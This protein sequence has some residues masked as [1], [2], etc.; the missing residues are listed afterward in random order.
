MGGAYIVVYVCDPSRPVAWAWF[1]GSD[2]YMEVNVFATPS[3]FDF[4]PN[5]DE[6][7]RSTVAQTY[8]SADGLVCGFSVFRIDQHLNAHLN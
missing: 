4:P 5:A 7:A 8:P 3:L 6:K 1:T 2:A